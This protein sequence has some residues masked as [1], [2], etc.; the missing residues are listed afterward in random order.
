MVRQTGQCDEK[1]LLEMRSFFYYKEH[2]VIVTELLRQ[3]LYE[4]GKFIRDND[5]IPYF[6]ISRLCHITR[7]VRRLEIAEARVVKMFLIM[8]L[9]IFF[10]FQF[11]FH[12]FSSPN[13][14]S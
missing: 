13:I 7:Q 10:E 12:F 11:I 4:F 1:N 5:E 8:H 6:T 3:N 9:L 14:L 2:L